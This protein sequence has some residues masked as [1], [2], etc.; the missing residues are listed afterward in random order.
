[1]W[2]RMRRPRAVRKN[3]TKLFL[4]LVVLGVA[5]SLF[6]GGCVALGPVKSSG[7]RV[8]A[9]YGFDA[10]CAIDPGPECPPK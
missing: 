9:P 6:L 4:V 2:R 7:E 1:M 8:A 5:L 3:V 10:H